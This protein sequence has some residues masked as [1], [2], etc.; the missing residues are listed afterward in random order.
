MWYCNPEWD[1]LFD[2]IYSE[3]DPARR[4]QLGRQVTRLFREDVAAIF[5]VLAPLYVIHAPRLRGVEVPATIG[6]WSL[7][8]VYK[9][10]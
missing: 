8:P 10:K 7:D 1:R 4:A 5:L 6:N 9:V 2:Q 3:R